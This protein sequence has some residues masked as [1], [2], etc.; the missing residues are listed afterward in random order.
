[1]LCGEFK[2]G[3]TVRVVLGPNNRLDLEAQTPQPS[4]SGPEVAEVLP[5]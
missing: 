2:T 1:M 4:T 5:G 3:D